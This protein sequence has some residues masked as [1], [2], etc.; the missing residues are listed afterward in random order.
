MR[1][2]LFKWLRSATVQNAQDH[3]TNLA[4]KSMGQIVGAQDPAY[5]PAVRYNAILIIGLLDQKYGE[6]QPPEPL[7]AALKPLTAV[8]DMATTSTRF[9]PSVIL[10]AVIGLDRHA[11]YRQTLSPEGAS[12]MSAALVKLVAH[13]EPIQ[14]MDRDS[15]SWLRLRAAGVLARL[16]S[17][18]E[19]NAVHDAIV[20]L[21]TSARSLDDRCLAAGLLEKLDY[22][23]VKL[24]D[25]TTADPL[26]ALARD[27]AAAEDKKALEFQETFANS[28]GFVGGYNADG[29]PVT[30]TFPRRQ[31][32]SRL[33]E[34]RNGLKKVKP[35][36]SEESQK[37]T[38]DVIAALST[39]IDATSDKSTVE[40]TLV[41]SL[42]KMADAINVAVPPAEPAPTEKV[43]ENAAFDETKTK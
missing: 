4:F 40:L 32:L 26:F 5:H 18:G 13:K 22:K 30:E 31:V 6:R 19:K 21:A 7:P 2:D 36:L 37:K 1:D 12:G 3:L 27:L 14:E 17:V 15:Y 25:A 28:G 16:G 35:A 10:G 41:D 34:L 20:K 23:D 29:T 39:A 43:D 33:V 38:D 24:E 42:R 8:V 9:P 11:Q